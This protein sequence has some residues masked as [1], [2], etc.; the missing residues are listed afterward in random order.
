MTPGRVKVW[1]TVGKHRPAQ[2]QVRQAKSRKEN[3]YVIKVMNLNREG[4]QVFWFA[5]TKGCPEPFNWSGK[6]NEN[7]WWEGTRNEKGFKK[8]KSR[9]LISQH[10]G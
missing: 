10:T 1:A 2:G 4:G 5:R 7:D 8:T 9:M 3:R 6:K